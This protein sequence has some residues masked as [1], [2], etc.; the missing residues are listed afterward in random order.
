[1]SGAAERKA[2]LKAFDKNWW[3]MGEEGLK[4]EEEAQKDIVKFFGVRVAPHLPKEWTMTPPEGTA[5]F[6]VTFET[7][8]ADKIPLNKEA[9]DE[10]NRLDAKG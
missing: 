1:M 10:L 3:P 9:T 5:G 4:M 8:R 6:K 7:V 2:V